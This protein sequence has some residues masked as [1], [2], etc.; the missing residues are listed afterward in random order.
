MDPFGIGAAFQGFE[1]WF[2]GGIKAA[3]GVGFRFSFGAIGVILLIVGLVAI[4]WS[5][6]DVRDAVSNAATTAAVAA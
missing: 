1:N 3:E 4:V 5:N 2:G 6:K